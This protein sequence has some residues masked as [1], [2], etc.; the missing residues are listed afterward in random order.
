MYV[1]ESEG[2]G[3]ACSLPYYFFVLRFVNNENGY[4]GCIARAKPIQEL[5]SESCARGQVN[6]DWRKVEAHVFL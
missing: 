3:L 6:Q 1:W 2:G 4:K 5:G